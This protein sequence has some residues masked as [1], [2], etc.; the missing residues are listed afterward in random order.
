MGKNSLSKITK[1]SQNVPNH[2]D[3]VLQ[4]NSTERDR[5]AKLNFEG[6]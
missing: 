5:L 6:F 2:S 3:K 4:T 1:C